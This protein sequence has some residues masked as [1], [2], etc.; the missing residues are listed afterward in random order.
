M[1]CAQ[2][3]IK[4]LVKVPNTLIDIPVVK[5]KKRVWIVHRSDR[6]PFSALA[7][8]LKILIQFENPLK[9]KQTLIWIKYRSI[10]FRVRKEAPSSTRGEDRYSSNSGLSKILTCKV[11]EV[12]GGHEF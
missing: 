9:L 4:Q 1:L 7:T 12:K 11:A 6:K 3:Q 2:N 5:S 10:F 8:K